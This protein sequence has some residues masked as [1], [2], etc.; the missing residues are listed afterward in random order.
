MLGRRNTISLVLD[1]L[2]NILFS[3]AHCLMEWKWNRTDRH[4]QSEDHRTM[5]KILNES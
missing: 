5:S 3:M 4:A 1:I 2:I